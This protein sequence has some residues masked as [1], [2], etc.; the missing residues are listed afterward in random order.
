MYYYFD[1]I[2]EVVD[3]ILYTKLMD[4][5]PQCIRFNKADGIIKIFDEIRYLELSNSYNEVYYRNNSRIYN[6]IFDRIN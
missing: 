1:D 3:N 4:A 5:K 2:M 6:A